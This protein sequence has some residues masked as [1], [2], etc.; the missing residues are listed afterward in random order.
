MKPCV[1][2]MQGFF[3]LT[4]SFLQDRMNIP[5]GNRYNSHMADP[6]DVAATKTVRQEFSKRMVDITYADLRVT[7]G[8]AYIRGSV[9]PIKG[10]PTDLKS[11]IELIAKVLRTRPGIKEV[12]V[13]CAI[14]S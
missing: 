12:V 6:A 9:K 14:R 10:G 1:V 4:H 5:L 13:D 3:L 11:E 7:H 8:V 2:T